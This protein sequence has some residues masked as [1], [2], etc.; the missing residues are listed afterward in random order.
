MTQERRKRY[1]ARRLHWEKGLKDAASMQKTPPISAFF[2]INGKIIER[3]NGNDY[4]AED[5]FWTPCKCEEDES[6]AWGFRA[7]GIDGQHEGYLDFYHPVLEIKG[8][9]VLYLPY[10]KLPLKSKRQSGFLMPTFSQRSS[11]GTIYSQPVY[12]AISENSDTTVNTEIYEKRGTKLGAELRYQ[13]KRYSGWEFNAESIRDRVWLEDRKRRID[14]LD[15]YL[16]ESEG[17]NDICPGEDRPTARAQCIRGVRSRLEPPDNTWRGAQKWRGL[18]IL[19]PR[20]SFVSNGEVYSD[21]RYVEELT[22]YEDFQS[23]LSSSERATLFSTTKYRFHLDAKNFYAGVGGAYGDNVLSDDQFKG[24]QLPFNAILQSRFYSLDRGHSPIPIYGQIA[25]RHHEI[26]DFVGNSSEIPQ[27][28]GRN[29]TLG[30]GNWQ[31]LKVDQV[32]P[33]VTHGIFKVNQFADWQVRNVKHEGLDEISSSIQSW[34]TGV[35]FNLP[36]DGDAPLPRWMQSESEP[37]TRNVR[38][39][40]N[41]AVTFSLRPEPI[42]RGPYGKYRSQFFRSDGGVN[43]G[44]ELVYFASDRS[45]YNDAADVPEQDHMV[46]HKRISFSTNHTWDIFTRGWERIAGDPSAAEKEKRLSYKERARRELL[47]SYDRPVSGLED[48]YDTETGSWYINRYSLQE[49]DK[50]RA[51]GFSASIS[52]DFEKVEAREKE[53]ERRRKGLSED[54]GQIGLP[55]PWSNPNFK[56][57]FNLFGVSLSNELEYDIYQK[58]PRRQ[59]FKLTPPSFYS[60]TISFGYIIDDEAIYD[61]D[62]KTQLFKRT[63][64]RYTN[65]STGLIPNVM[66]TGWFGR[67][68]EKSLIAK[69]GEVDPPPPLSNRNRGDL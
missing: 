42:R 6:P 34:R 24:Q 55:K 58:R 31:Q 32:A 61:S 68:T 57:G 5:A 69:P 66:L 63:E 50:V 23:A 17:I 67:K 54:K 26:R 12:F 27:V 36:M 59:K 9:P 14:A 18:S 2:R 48:M 25:A 20:L 16:G 52:Y 10:L 60:T 39:Y 53:K 65:I 45:T 43:Q 33:L 30:E 62:I 38:H 28:E 41:W 3:K 44:G 35:T 4:H 13:Q 49:S 47:Y 8:V 11:S 46:S 21:H 1:K 51:A 64:E 40:M 56:L 22:L 19:A 37:G 29:R 15:Y 7:T